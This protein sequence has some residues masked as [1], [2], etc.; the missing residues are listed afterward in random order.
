ME[1]CGARHVEAEPC[2]SLADG[3][4][5]VEEFGRNSGDTLLNSRRGTQVS[6]IK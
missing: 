5:G 4:T 2:H 3:R 6:E 1:I